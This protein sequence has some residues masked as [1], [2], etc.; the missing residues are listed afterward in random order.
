M[1]NM[2]YYGKYRKLRRNAENYGSK[3]PYGGFSTVTEN[4]REIQ[5]NTGNYGEV[6]KTSALIVLSHNDRVLLALIV[7]KK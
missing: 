1:E 2:E 5:K 6:W 4:Y 7:K 3:G